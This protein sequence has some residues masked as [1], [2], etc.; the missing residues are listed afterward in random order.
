[1]SKLYSKE[2]GQEK[3]I[4]Y[5]KQTEML[6][7]PQD[8]FEVIKQTLGTEFAQKY[9]EKTTC[10]NICVATQSLI[11]A[12][13]LQMI[14]FDERLAKIEN[15]EQDEEPQELT[16][17]PEDEATEKISA[18]ITEHPGSRTSDIICDLGLNPN[19]VLRILRKLKEEKKITGKDIERK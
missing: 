19:L 12:L 7:I 6:A 15:I 4:K 3:R 18:F 1:V 17:I 13:K 10:M 16:I 14:Q 8:Y 5:Y 2:L 9:V 11:E